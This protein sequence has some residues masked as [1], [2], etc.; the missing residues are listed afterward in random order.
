[1]TP[2]F[3]ALD[4][5]EHFNPFHS[6]HDNVSKEWSHGTSLGAFPEA[7]RT[8]GEGCL[9]IALAFCRSKIIFAFHVVIFQ[10][11]ASL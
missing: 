5:L 10:R 1:V 2:V 4:L 11:R 9:R 7:K 8:V 3:V 6:W